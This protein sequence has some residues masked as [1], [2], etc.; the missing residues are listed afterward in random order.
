MFRQKVEQINTVINDFLR[1]SGIE[2]PLL[3]RRLINSWEDVAGKSVAKYTRDIYIN[4]QTLM[5]KI[6]NPALRQDL[7][8]RKTSLMKQ[9]NDSVGSIVIYD[10]RIY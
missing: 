2:T 4:N 7:A 6:T 3:Q 9:L 8:M 1:S 5:V 10:I